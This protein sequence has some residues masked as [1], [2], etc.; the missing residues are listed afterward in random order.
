MIE[1]SSDHPILNRTGLPMPAQAM[2]EF[3]LAVLL[4]VGVMM[5]IIE[6]ARWMSTYY[7]LS[8]A[9]SEGARVGALLAST[10]SQI[11]AAT[12]FSL[13]PWIFI[14]PD[15]DV[16]IC[17]LPTAAASD[18]TC[19]NAAA[20]SGNFIQVKLTYAFQWSLFPIWLGQIADQTITVSDR[21][22]ID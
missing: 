7:M 15:T 18:T 1:I 6:G 3:S 12:Q 8:N 13:G 5:A 11:R 16:T 4:L 22:R 14:D 19:P 17:R 20:T 2:V 9:A 21:Q 10:D